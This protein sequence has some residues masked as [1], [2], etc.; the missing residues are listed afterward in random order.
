MSDD[1]DRDDQHPRTNEPREVGELVKKAAGA[2]D[3]GERNEAWW[4]E[5][6]RRI[7]ELRAQE[8]A[9][10]EAERLRKRAVDLEKIGGFPRM[11]IETAMG[12][13]AD[14][15]AM[16]FA[17]RFP[18]MPARVIVF[19]GGVGAGKTTAA[20][21]LALRGEDRDPGFIRASTLERRGRYDKK[22]DAWLE[23]RTSLVIDDLGVEVLDSKRV[24]A[25]LLDE[26]VDHFYSR[27]RSLIMTTNLLPRATDEMVAEAKK[28][29]R[30][31]EPQF[32][33]RYGDRVRSRIRQ[34]GQWADCGTLDLRN[35]R[36][37]A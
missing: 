25:A 15:P 33:E 30:E 36:G 4:R 16:D 31:P 6:D 23:E 7:A 21:W 12:K 34:I 28:E 14:T 18:F 8:S 19:A 13:P 37:Q 5:R 1:D 9:K 17:R 10:A 11:C 32:I 2:A 27:R 3:A 35:P 26:I 29:N 24:F 22:L 20:C